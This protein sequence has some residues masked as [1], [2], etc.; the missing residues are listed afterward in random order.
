[1]SSFDERSWEE[2][3]EGRACRNWYTVVQG[4]LD[5]DDTNV[6]NL[7]GLVASVDNL[8]LYLAKHKRP[9]CTDILSWK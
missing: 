7:P 3:E 5:I 2:T 1:M 9:C 6:I 4:N 8:F